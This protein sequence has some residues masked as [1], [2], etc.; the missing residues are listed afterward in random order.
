[1]FSV[2]DILFLKYMRF[3]AQ[4]LNIWEI[5]YNLYADD[6]QLYLLFEVENIVDAIGHAKE[7]WI[8]IQ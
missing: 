5:S 6:T 2:S 1:M 4:L 3:I 7:I 8:K